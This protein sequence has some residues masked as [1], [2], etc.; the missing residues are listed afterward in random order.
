MYLI[1]HDVKSLKQFLLDVKQFDLVSS[2]TKKLPPWKT[3]CHL[4]TNVLSA[5]YEENDISSNIRQIIASTGTLFSGDIIR[6]FPINDVKFKNSSFAK[7]ETPKATICQKWGVLTTI[8]SPP[9]E[10]V[11][12]FSYLNDWCLVVVGDM[13]TPEEVSNFQQM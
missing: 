11:R 5:N 1:V 4:N 13:K 3:F 8:F 10:A 12:R 6:T 2:L 7:V 9:S